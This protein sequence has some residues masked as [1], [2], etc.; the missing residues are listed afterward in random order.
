MAL[1]DEKMS[2][3]GTPSPDIFMIQTEDDLKAYLQL[4]QNQYGRRLRR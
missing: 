4:Q 2:G 1:K 3:E